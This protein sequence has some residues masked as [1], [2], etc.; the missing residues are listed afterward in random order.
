MKKIYVFGLT[1]LLIL[2]IRVELAGQQIPISTQHIFTPG[3]FNPAKTA[4]PRLSQVY[5]GAFQHRVQ[6]AN[7]KSATQFIDFK[8]SELGSGKKF[9]WGLQLSNDIQHT[10]WLL[11]VSPSVAVQILNGKRSR[12][13]LGMSGGLINWQGNYAGADLVNTE[14]PI[15][16]NVGFIE[17]DAGI[18]ATFTHVGKG[19]K[20]DLGISGHQL[21]GNFATEQLQGI[22]LLPHVVASGGIMVLPVHN[23]LIGPR[24]LY[25]NTV[26]RGDTTLVAGNVDLGLKVEFPRQSLWFAGAY[27]L[28]RAALTFGMGSKFTLQDT[29]SKKQQTAWY[30]A[31]NLG[32]NYP[33][34]DSKALGPGAEVGI[35]LSFDRINKIS[36]ADTLPLAEVFWLNDGNLNRHKDRY[37]SKSITPITHVTDRRVNLTYSFMDHSYLFMGENPKWQGNHLGEIGEEWPFADETISSVVNEVIKEGLFPNEEVRDPENLEPL[38][39]LIWV[40]LSAKLRINAEE[41]NFGAKGQKYLGELGVNNLTE[42]SLLLFVVYDDKDT[43]IGIRVNSYVTNLELAC[44][45]LHAMRLRL[46]NEL[47]RAYGVEMAFI[48]EEDRNKPKEEDENQNEETEDEEDLDEIDIWDGR[49]PVYIRTLRLTSDHPNLQAFQVNRIKIRFARHP[50]SVRNPVEDDSRKARRK[51]KKKSKK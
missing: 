25:R 41:A 35:T 45:K 29:L 20:A 24:F 51:K 23:L 14:D 47:E 28:D 4:D 1:L 9:S 11:R 18:G 40:S 13:T 32:F 43:T 8:S 46:E 34:N 2:G 50:E 33:M 36:K 10:D 21:P 27:R 16:S 22:R 19:M 30:L 15:L 3:F 6:I 17:L 7:G 42:D 48:R 5:L 31:F 39:K 37:F 49:Q 44:L 26:N 38:K 12:L